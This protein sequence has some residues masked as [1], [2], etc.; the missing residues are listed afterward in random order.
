MLIDDFVTRLAWDETGEKITLQI[1]PTANACQQRSVWQVMVARMK[2]I[3][4]WAADQ[5]APAYWRP[6]ADIVNCN[7]CSKR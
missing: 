3:I 4:G 5:V 2:F 1:D 7:N 6:N